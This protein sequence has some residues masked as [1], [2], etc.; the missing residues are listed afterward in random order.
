[1]QMN[2]KVKYFINFL[3]RNNC[4]S[5]FIKN[6]SIYGNLPYCSDP[7]EYIVNT[8]RLKDLLRKIHLWPVTRKE[9]IYWQQIIKAWQEHCKWLRYMNIE[10]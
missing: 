7:I 5:K 6:L 9:Y 2:I 1:M 8:Y 10:E 4:H 3:K